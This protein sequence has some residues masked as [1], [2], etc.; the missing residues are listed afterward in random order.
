MLRYLEGVWDDGV[1]GSEGKVGWNSG[2]ELLPWES[3]RRLPGMWRNSKGERLAGTGREQNRELR[4]GM[5]E[6]LEMCFCPE[7][8]F[9]DV[10]GCGEFE[11]AEDVPERV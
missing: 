4:D 5:F 6:V 7:G 10:R 11:G 1:S 9:G 2:D 8:C 3:F